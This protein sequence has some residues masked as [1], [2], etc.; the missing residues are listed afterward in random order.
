MPDRAKAGL[1]GKYKVISAYIRKEEILKMNQ[2][3]IS[4]I[5][6]PKKFKKIIGFKSLDIYGKL[7]NIKTTTKSEA[8]KQLKLFGKIW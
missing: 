3:S 8:T 7:D 4:R 2:E 6:L 1:K 5:A